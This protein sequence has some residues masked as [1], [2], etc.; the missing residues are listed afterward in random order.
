MSCLH[1]A[2]LGVGHWSG[3]P[4]SRSDRCGSTANTSAAHPPALLGNTFHARINRF[5]GAE[6]LFD[7][8]DLPGAADSDV[9]DTRELA[10]LQA[11]F[12]R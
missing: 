3:G 5:Y 9:G 1:S 11:A 12:G 10:A 8:A 7:L 4:G 2:Q 6:R